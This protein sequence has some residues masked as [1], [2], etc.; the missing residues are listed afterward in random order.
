MRRKIAYKFTNCLLRVYRDIHPPVGRLYESR[1]WI[2][3]PKKRDIQPAIIGMS[4][5]SEHQMYFVL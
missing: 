4:D 1:W 5:H 3:P 2:I